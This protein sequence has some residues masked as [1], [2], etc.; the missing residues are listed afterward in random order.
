MTISSIRKIEPIFTYEEFMLALCVWRE[1]R[2][3]PFLGQQYIAQVIRNRAAD[4]NRWPNNIVDVILQPYQF[5]AFNP[6]DPNATKFPKN[7]D[8]SWRKCCTAILPVPEVENDGA[9]HYHVVGAKVT[10]DK[11]PK[12]SKVIG[13]HVFFRL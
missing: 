9:N 1:G 8:P 11:N 5:S 6:E 2:G 4:K 7:T 10:W 12:W 3:E 13:N